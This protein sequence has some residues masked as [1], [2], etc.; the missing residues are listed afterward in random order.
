MGVGLGHYILSIVWSRAGSVQA[1]GSLG[2]PEDFST[3]AGACSMGDL[4]V[5]PWW[6]AVS[7]ELRFLELVRFETY[8]AP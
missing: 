7:S 4:P 6:A 5:C 8:E 2:R 1:P 3:R